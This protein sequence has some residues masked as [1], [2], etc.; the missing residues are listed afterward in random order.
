MNIEA[1]LKP[2][3]DWIQPLEEKIGQ[4]KANLFVSAVQKQALN[5]SFLK[6]E[7]PSYFLEKLASIELMD[8]L[9]SLATE[10]VLEKLPRQNALKMG[11]ASKKEYLQTFR[12]KLVAFFVGM[13]ALAI[14]GI[15]FG[16]LF[17]CLWG[18]EESVDRASQICSQA[19]GSFWKSSGG[20]A[21]LL[22]GPL[23]LGAFL[24]LFGE[25]ELDSWVYD[26][27]LQDRFKKMQE[28]FQKA[29]DK[30]NH[31]KSE[32]Q[33]KAKAL[34]NQVALNL[35]L[36]RSLLEIELLFTKE[37]IQEILAPLE[38]SCKRGKAL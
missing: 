11:Y 35:P 32:Q 12:Q 16:S 34:S 13:K 7:D 10:K 36:I 23:S 20:K 4:F 1:V 21:I 25:K 30:L 6:S 19:A 2:V 5:S 31:M 29:A 38:I 3:R 17:S 37:Q 15:S 9:S 24:F 28:M 14:L 27:G 8:P 22:S 18:N 26:P 33:A